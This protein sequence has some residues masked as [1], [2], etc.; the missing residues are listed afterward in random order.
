MRAATSACERGAALRPRTA[1]GEGGVACDA[2][3]GV[4]GLP[5]RVAMPADA[6]PATSLTAVRGAASSLRAD[7]PSIRPSIR[8]SFMTRQFA[9]QRRD[10]R[11][12]RIEHVS[13]ANCNHTVPQ[14]YPRAMC[15]QD[16]FCPLMRRATALGTHDG[17]YPG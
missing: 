3:G 5:P 17:C 9:G 12:R 4:E 16:G 6:G 15:F 8:S 7:S 1:C 13:Y 10:W 2:P 11:P 14:R